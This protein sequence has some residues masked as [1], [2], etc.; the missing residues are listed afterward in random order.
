MKIKA[1]T[2]KVLVFKINIKVETKSTIDIMRDLLLSRNSQMLNYNYSR[3]LI[4][5]VLFYRIFNDA[6][7]NEPNVRLFKQYHPVKKRIP[8]CM[9]KKCTRLRLL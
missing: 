8:F 5:H 6:N 3:T 4:I 2:L 7:K 1:Y 9:I